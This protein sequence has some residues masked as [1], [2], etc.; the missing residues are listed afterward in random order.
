MSEPDDKIPAGYVML[1]VASLVVI[2]FAVRA[3]P[4][5]KEEMNWWKEFFDEN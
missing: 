4:A 2:F 3:T 1:G 5:W